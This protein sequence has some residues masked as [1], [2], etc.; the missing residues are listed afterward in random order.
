MCLGEG[1]GQAFVCVGGESIRDSGALWSL[2][3]VVLRLCVCVHRCVSTMQ[4]A[5]AALLQC[6]SLVLL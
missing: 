3:I 4:V 1:L 6:G 2:C 5:G